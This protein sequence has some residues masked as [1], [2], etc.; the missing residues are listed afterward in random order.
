MGPAFGV[1]SSWNDPAGG[2]TIL[3]VGASAR[4][5][6][7][8]AQRGGMN[9]WAADMFGDRDLQ[10]CCPCER[11]E[12]YPHGLERALAAAP[13]GPWMYTGALENY[14]DLVDRI[15]ALRPLYGMGGE[16]LRAVR[17]PQRLAAVVHADGFSAPRCSRS[18]ANVPTDGSWL[19]KPQASAGGHHI[20]PWHGEV[21]HAVRGG[22]AARSPRYFQEQ[23]DGLPASAVCIGTRDG[24]NCLGVTR[25][26]LGL[27]WCGA[28][29]GTDR[30]RYCGSIG[31]LDL[32]AQLAER[33]EELGS[34]MA[35][36]FGL[37][38]LFGVDVIVHGDEIWAIE[39]NPRY[40]ASIEVLERICA[41]NAVNL[42]I[43]AFSASSASSAFQTLKRREH[44]GRRA[45]GKAVLYAPSNVVIRPAFLDWAESQNSGLA[46]PTVAD[47]PSPG[48]KIRAAQPIVTV[49]AEDSD[50]RSVL[51]GLKALAAEAYWNLAVSLPSANNSR[52]EMS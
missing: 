4:A 10:A 13:A 22:A 7:M 32:S 21:G 2:E 6:A 24:A 20:V 16:S 34:T 35:R 3:I 37:V 38:G 17:D 49:F 26:L 9:P 28:N 25:Q 23:V 5:A 1:S 8:S 14:P 42:H 52:A 33:F 45:A 39:V 46:W 11:I 36:S 47:I 12:N 40:T 18:S 27:P 15:A 43:Q 41:M 50:E 30:F 48:T 29:R 51:N 31:P 19:S 44:R